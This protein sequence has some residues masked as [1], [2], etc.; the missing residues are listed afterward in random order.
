MNVL[1]E[2]GTVGNVDSE[3]IEVGDLVTV[4]LHNENGMPI[5]EIG[6]VV[7]IL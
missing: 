7:E 4:N 2:T 1:L 5:E 3:D 6:I